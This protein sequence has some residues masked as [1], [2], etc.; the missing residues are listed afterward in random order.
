MLQQSTNDIHKQSPKTKTNH[1]QKSGK[2]LTPLQISKSTIKPYHQ[3]K[4]VPKTSN[5]SSNNK[6]LNVGVVIKLKTMRWTRTRCGTFPL[7]WD[8]AAARSGLSQYTD[9]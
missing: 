7:A 9:C 6:K 4:T 5:S 8:K 3:P 1:A 2:L